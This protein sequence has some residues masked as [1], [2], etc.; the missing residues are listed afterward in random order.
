MRSLRSRLTSQGLG[1][2]AIA[3]KAWL[4]QHSFHNAKEIAIIPLL[5]NRLQHTSLKARILA[6]CFDDL[7]G[8][9][10][11]T[12]GFGELFIDEMTLA[13]DIIDDDDGSTTTHADALI[14]IVEVV[15]FVGVDLGRFDQCLPA[16]HIVGGADVN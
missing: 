15:L 11:L 2:S 4:Q 10:D 13:D 1:Q 6:R 7:T 3:L 9:G 8:S 5:S 16:R 12:I 14:E